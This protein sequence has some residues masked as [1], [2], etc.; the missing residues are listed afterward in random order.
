MNDNEKI[1]SFI[2]FCL[3]NNRIKICK[4]CKLITH[5]KIDPKNIICNH[6]FNL[7]T[8]NNNKNKY[9]IDVDFLKWIMD[10]IIFINS[11][12]NKI[13]NILNMEVNKNKS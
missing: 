4:Y 1:K 3:E 7:C 13:E 12:F 8:V 5:I 6:E 11:C 9:L 10:N 2:V